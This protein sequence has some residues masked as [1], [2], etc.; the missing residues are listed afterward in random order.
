MGNSA[1]IMI[2]PLL[3]IGVSPARAA[4]SQEAFERRYR[5]TPDP[6]GFRS[7]TY[8][9]EKYDATIAALSRTRYGRAFEPGCS[10]GELTARLA[11][12]CDVVTATDF[13]ASAVAQARARCRDLGNV[14]V[15]EA[16]LAETLP[17]G[18]LDLIIFSELGYYFAKPLLSD[19]VH[20][21]ARTLESGGEFVAVHWLGTSED[22]VMHGD[23]VHEVLTASM[24]LA[25][26][27]SERRPGFR[28][29]V[30]TR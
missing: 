13:S 15:E 26:V 7:S 28:L 1:S 9:R 17:Q 29:D 22:H 14:T 2:K 11:E 4:C 23:E 21:L 6:W 16:D 24:P 27:K 19:I 25:K 30:W 20:R 3:R 8:E 18:P 10:V 12:R 5:E